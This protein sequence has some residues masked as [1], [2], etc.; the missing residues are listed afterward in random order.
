MANNLN[1]VHG[2]VDR[3]EYYTKYSDVKAELDNYDLS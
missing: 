3:D 1:G 2:K